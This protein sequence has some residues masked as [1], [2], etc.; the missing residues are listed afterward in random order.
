[1]MRRFTMA[2]AAASNT[3]FRPLFAIESTGRHDEAAQCFSTSSG[4]PSKFSQEE[5]DAI[6][7][8][9]KRRGGS[10]SFAR[11]ILERHNRDEEPGSARYIENSSF[12][13]IPYSPGIGGARDGRFASVFHEQHSLGDANFYGYAQK[14]ISIVGC[15][16]V[17][18]GTAFAILN[19]G[20]SDAL[21][22]MDV[23]ADRIEGEVN[24]LR[25]GSAFYGHRARVEGSTDYAVTAESDL[26]IVTA[27]VAQK[28]GESRLSLLGRNAAI[29]G[30][31]IPQVLEHSP[32]AAICVV[33]NPCDIM[34]A[35]ACK[36]AGP[37]VPP[38]RI[39]GSG[40]VL[41]SSRLQTLLGTT[42][43]VDPRDCRGYV[44]GEHGDSS[45]P[46]FSSVKIGGVPLMP[47]GEGAP[48]DSHITMHRE[49]VESAGDVIL[50]K[51]YTNWVG[52]FVARF[53][54][55]SFW[56]SFLV[57]CHLEPLVSY[58]SP[59]LSSLPTFLA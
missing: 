17:G 58:S 3:I 24:D 42:L 5:I 9:T 38:G 53:R 49:V 30:S 52:I 37:D 35:F 43:D 4:G 57:P 27:G 16:Q 12:R 31:V 54:F 10:E 19:Q 34:A 51:G 40:T 8:R 50:K 6:S 7:E 41:D 25:Q 44:I 1:M 45:V 29:M 39:F 14:K 11:F 48:E 56:C 21:A 55:F 26:V 47:E 59:R 2:K 20:V 15:G 36:I 18:L 32:D 22:L 13:P 33:S 28:P 46:V 23:N